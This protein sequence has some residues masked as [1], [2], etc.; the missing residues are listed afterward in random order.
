MSI[1]IVFMKTKHDD[2]NS[3]PVDF[4]EPAFAKYSLLAAA[5]VGTFLGMI[6]MGRLG[7]VVGRKP[8]MLLAT[9]L[10]LIS[11]L[12]S[13]VAWGDS[14]T[15]YTILVIAR[16]FSGVGVGGMYPLAFS[17]AV[18][19]ES[20][21]STS[22]TSS[23]SSS[24][25]LFSSTSLSERLLTHPSSSSASLA[26]PTD[27]V[28]KDHHDKGRKAA[29]AYL[30]QMFGSLSPYVVALATLLLP[31]SIG[32]LTSLQ[33]R[34][35]IGS[36]IPTVLLL[37]YLTC[38]SSESQEFLAE[39]EYSLSKQLQNRNQSDSSSIWT[40]LC[41]ARYRTRL[42]GVAGAWMLYD[43]AYYGT[44]VFTPDILQAIFGP[45]D[46]LTG[47]CWQAIVFGSF[48]I[49]GTLLGIWQVDRGG[50]WLNIYGFL[51]MAAAFA[52]LAVTCTIAPTGHAN[53][54]KFVLFCF[55][56]FALSWGPVVGCH[57]LPPKLFPVRIRS[58]F[59]GLA[60]AGGK[61]GAIVGVFVYQPIQERWGLLAVLWLMV[62]LALAGWL[63]SVVCL[64]DD[65][66][67]LDQDDQDDQDR[68][69]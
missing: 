61:V 7:D 66:L 34:L 55:I 3:K 46:G 68:P 26:S 1:A 35:I 22:L 9:T 47:I 23:T 57:I 53:I 51:V 33:F 56:S 15:L 25:S 49:P 62:G 10:L 30:W 5:Y 16:F 69:T 50:R 13:T 67:P 18:E 41:N 4:P 40:H 42:I 52:C 45:E 65:R 29:W 64:P 32:P 20:T 63:L 27:S 36:A 38:I 14:N 54:I 2:T 58:T 21:T 28:V 17:A 59:S 37:L 8:G 43:I 48:S 12:L 24:S 11:V 6:C 31:T 39:R 60:A 44:S 19:H